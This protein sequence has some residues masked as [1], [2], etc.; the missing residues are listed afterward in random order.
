MGTIEFNPLYT[1]QSDDAVPNEP[2][3][4]EDRETNANDGADNRSA[5]V[6]IAGN[7]IVSVRIQ[8]K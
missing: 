2:R 3:V 7:S 6:N 8:V 1:K 4:V 5:T